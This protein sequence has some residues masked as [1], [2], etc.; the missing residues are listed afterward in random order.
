[1]STQRKQDSAEFKA[2]VA[3]EALK[4]LKTGNA[5]ARTYGGQPTQMAPWKHRLQQESPELCSARRAKREQDQEALQAQLYQQIGQLKGE[6][7]WLKKKLDLPREAQRELLEAAPPQLSSARQCA[8]V[9]LPRST[10][11]SHAQGESAEHLT[12]MRRLDEPYPETPYDGVRRMT[13]WLRRHGDAV[14]HKRVAR[15]LRTLG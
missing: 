12:V 8:L 4:G 15:L 11:S 6:L 3:L 1:M 10:S 14:H 5:L 2:R 7:D 13:A 9:G